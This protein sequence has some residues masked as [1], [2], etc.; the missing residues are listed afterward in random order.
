MTKVDLTTLT[1]ASVVGLV[2]TGS[3]FV[4]LPILV[5][6]LHVERAVAF[7]VVQILATIITFF[8]NKYWAFSAGNI[9]KIHTQFM[10]QLVIAAGSMA[11]NTAIPSLLTYRLHVEPVLAFTISQVCVYFAWNYPGNRFWVFRK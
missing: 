4:T 5:Y 7:F 11:L 1:K 8:L 2:A 10:K 6:G 9:G 3:E